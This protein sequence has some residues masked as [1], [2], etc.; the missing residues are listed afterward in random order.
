[1]KKPDTIRSLLGLSQENLALI[2]RVS[3]SQI[4]MYELG[5]RNLPVYAIEKLAT[6][7]TLSQ[8]ESAKNEAKNSISIHEQSFLKKLLLKNTHQQLLVERKIRTLEKKHNVLETSKKVVSHLLKDK[9]NIKKSE[10]A[11]L[12]AIA[13]KSKN[14]DTQ[15]YTTELLQLEL[16]KEVLRFEEK[17]LL[18]KLK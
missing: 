5:K 8:N 18:K 15:S 1:M 3:R 7:L 10:L 4:A 11:V 9:N 13:V 17:L 2:L 6:L 14:Q 12:K 16:K